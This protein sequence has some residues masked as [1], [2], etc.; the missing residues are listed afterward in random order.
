[1]NY[2][3]AAESQY[4]IGDAFGQIYDDGIPSLSMAYNLMCVRTENLTPKLAEL[5]AKLEMIL[6]D[7]NAQEEDILRYVEYI[8][9]YMGQR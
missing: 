7:I 9:N 2:R 1:M 6:F 8:D 4:V 5:Q 3:R